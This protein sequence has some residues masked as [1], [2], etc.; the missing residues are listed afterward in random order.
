MDVIKNQAWKPDDH[1]NSSHTTGTNNWGSNST[2]NQSFGYAIAEANPTV[3]VFNQNSNA[4]Q[5]IE[6]SDYVEDGFN[7]GKILPSFNIGTSNG[8]WDNL[9]GVT[10]DLA[11]Y[12]PILLFTNKKYMFIN[13]KQKIKYEPTVFE[14]ATSM[15]QPNWRF[16]LNYLPGDD[17]YSSGIDDSI[18]I[19][20][21]KPLNAQR[22]SKNSIQK[23]KNK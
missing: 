2:P 12:S 10:A 13:M 22:L 20:Y 6:T 11:S 15:F 23:Q 14:M 8:F 21:K 7:Y 19:I 5:M 16:G 4:Q 17:F 3:H 18:S 9:K 1:R